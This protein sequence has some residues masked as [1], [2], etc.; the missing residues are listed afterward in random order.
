[1]YS[2]AFYRT[3]Y[4]PDD[5]LL[6]CGTSVV[7]GS[8]EAV[9]GRVF[10]SRVLST[11]YDEWSSSGHVVLSVSGEIGLVSLLSI[12]TPQVGSPKESVCGDGWFW[13]VCSRSVV[14]AGVVL[15]MVYRNEGCTTSVVCSWC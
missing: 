9:Y 5:V 7:E 6:T 12:G 8:D 15:R 11:V 14:G 2:L 1:M 4:K 10:P 3:F 13:V